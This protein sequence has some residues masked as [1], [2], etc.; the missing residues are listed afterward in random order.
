VDRSSLIIIN[1]HLETRPKTLRRERSI[2]GDINEMLA[3]LDVS[4]SVGMFD[5]GAALIR[6]LGTLLSADSS[7]LLNLHNKYIRSMVSYMILS[8]NPKMVWPAQ[9]WFEVD[10]RHG[11]VQPDA[12]TY[13]LMVRMS[14]RMLHGP[15][16]DRTVRRYWEL[17][18]RTGVEEELLG[19]PV[20][21]ELDLGELSEVGL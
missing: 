15:K 19:L 7:E 4:L 10:M 14:L 6:R 13:A 11:G 12:T 16:R 17:A 9:R 1:D 21:S 8:R 18:K 2:G 3:N 5:R 20:L